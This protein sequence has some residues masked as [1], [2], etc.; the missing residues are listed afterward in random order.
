[1]ILETNNLT[2]RFGRLTAVNKVNLRIPEGSIFGMLGPNGSGK[3]TTLG[4]LL[5]VINPTEG[6]FSWFGQGNSPEIRKNIGAILEQPIFYPYMSAVR[7]LDIVCKI[8]QAATSR[9]ET[10]LKQVN[11]FDRKD[12]KFETYSLGMKQRLAIASALLCDPKVLVLDEPTNGLDPQGIAEIRQIISNIAASGKSIILASHLLDE[13][14]KVCTDFCVLQNSNLIYQGSVAE[15]F[16]ENTSIEI[17]S[18]NHSALKTALT[19]IS[20]VKDVIEQ[21]QIILVKGDDE[22]DSLSLNQQL[23]ERG[24]VVSHLKTIE[25]SLEQRFLEILEGQND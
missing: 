7:N 20:G 18:V 24:V 17:A 9:I 15:D 10:V 4:M 25:K 2:K 8:K 3:T 1:M 13:V 14:Q 21:G 12:D 6:E 22:L 16:A 5:G 23:I 11:L 19:K